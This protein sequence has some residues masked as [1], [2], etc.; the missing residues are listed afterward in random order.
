M[1]AFIEQMIT[2]YG[3][4]LVARWIETGART[5]AARQAKKGKPKNQEELALTEQLGELTEHDLKQ[6]LDYI[7]TGQ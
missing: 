6:L 2:M 5:Y 7:K 4:K 1:R 3:D